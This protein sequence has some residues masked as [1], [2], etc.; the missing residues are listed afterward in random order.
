MY[1]FDVKTWLA[2]FLP[3]MQNRIYAH[4]FKFVEKEK[5]GVSHV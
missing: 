3:V 4:A 1:I 2:P 5:K